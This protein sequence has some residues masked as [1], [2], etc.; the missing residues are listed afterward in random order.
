VPV[1]RVRAAAERS[2]RNPKRFLPRENQPP[3]PCAGGLL[4]SRRGFLAR[5]GPSGHSLSLFASQT[6]S[7]AAGARSRCPEAGGIP[8]E[9]DLLSAAGQ[10]D[11]LER[12]RAEPK[13]DQG[14]ATGPTRAT[15]TFGNP[16]IV[17]GRSRRE[18]GNILVSARGPITARTSA[19][20]LYF[21]RVFRTLSLSNLKDEKASFRSGTYGERT[22]P[23]ARAKTIP[24]LILRGL[25]RAN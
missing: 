13:K 14:A 8:S 19:L 15:S 10:G 17:V 18:S 4:C 3:G 5:S 16:V 22:R 1:S 24:H 25:N 23:S 7:L 6:S 20:I 21:C 2:T 12:G 11:F 9:A